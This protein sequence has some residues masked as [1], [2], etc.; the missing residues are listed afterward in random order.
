MYMKA[1]EVLRILRIS[2]NTLSEYVK[3]GWIRVTKL[4]NGRYI[5]NDE[6]VWKLAAKTKDERK[7]VIYAR[8]STPKQKPDLENQ[9]KFLE[10][11]AMNAG[12]K[13]DLVIKDIGSG[14]DLYNRKGL[15]KLLDL[16]AKYQ[17]RYVIVAYK[18]RLTRIGFDFLKHV[19]SSQL[20][21][22]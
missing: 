7:T 22:V 13:V 19:S 14:V 2:R 16:V 10:N 5:Y 12:Y 18:D 20:R 1:A 8:V 6:D 15:Q 4:P 17:V 3:R 21:T 11:W 9:V